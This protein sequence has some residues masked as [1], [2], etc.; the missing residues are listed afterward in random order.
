MKARPMGAATA[1]ER[2]HLALLRR[3]A[4]LQ[5]DM[6]A[7]RSQHQH[8]MEH[9]QAR[10][11]RLQAELVIRHTHTLWGL[12]HRR[13]ALTDSARHSTAGPRLERANPAFSAA[14]A[15][16]AAICQSGCIAQAHAWLGDEQQCRLHG[17]R[18]EPLNHPQESPCASP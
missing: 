9:L 11:L 1:L 13:F 8:Q 17:G 14:D 6:D 18:C 10:L 3:W 7:L 16:R 12:G 5:H 15:T 2:E 4:Q